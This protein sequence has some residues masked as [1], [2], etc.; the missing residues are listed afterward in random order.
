MSTPTSAP[1]HL[2]LVEDEPDLRRT[3][4]YNLKRAGYTLTAVENGQAAVDILDA[5][6]R[7]DV[8]PIDMVVSDVM[9]PVMDGMAF[10]KAMRARPATRETPLLFL[11]AKGE[12]EDRLQG[13]R[14]GADDYLTK[15]FDLEELLARVHVQSRRARATAELRGQLEK[16]AAAAPLAD[17]AAPPARPASDL[18]AKVAKWE[19]RFPGLG[20]I[21]QDRIVGESQPTLALLKEILL[22]APGS[23]P[24]L[25]VGGTGTGKT[26]VAEAL[27]QLGPRAEGPFRTVNC[28]ELA[29]ADPAIT[30]GKLF[31]YG[32][33][34][35]LA[36]VPA[37]GQPG[38]LEDLDGGTL[39]LDE[40]HQLPLEA[41]AMLLHPVEGKS[42]NPAVGKG[43]PRRVDVKFVFATN[44]DLRAEVESG[45]FPLD[46]Y[47]RLAACQIRVPGLG[48]RRED[49]PALAQHFLDECKGEFDIPDA[50]FAPSLTRFL[51]GRDWPG[52]IR[53]LRAMVREIAR[54]AAFELDAVLTTEHLPGDWQVG[55]VQGQ[56]AQ[57]IRAPDPAMP[58]A[59]STA[60]PAQAAAPVSPAVTGTEHGRPGLEDDAEGLW[61]GAE[62]RELVALR[63]HRFKMAAAEQELGLSSKSRTLTNHL[64]GMCF[65]ALVRAS[66]DVSTAAQW[67]IGVEDD[68][69]LDR[70]ADRIEGYVGMVARHVS[71]HT[72]STLFNNLPRDYRKFVEASIERARDAERAAR[73]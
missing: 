71:A 20:P 51:A 40:I 58:A 65:K 54:R 63:T 13:F 61:N 60:A 2:L 12:R 37:K 10:A 7:G 55:V 11:T 25:I 49:I 70:L 38:L 42:F 62:L 47:Q 64:R 15:P 44:L 36:N 41:Q 18:Y 19:Q 43:E 33:G 68:A 3:L 53:E 6:E 29:A 34:S 72:T 73:A 57:S 31:G 35:G 4:K 17:D 22:R 24:V 45:R 8:Q 26:G 69:L 50:T 56:V 16:A 66:F 48:E 28:A 52:N 39:F 14:V 1:L 9:M 67:V 30:L 46:L 5:A 23:D 59:P 32:S 21:R 27:W